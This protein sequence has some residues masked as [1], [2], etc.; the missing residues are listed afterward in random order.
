MAQPGT[1]LMT[2]RSLLALLCLFLGIAQANTQT[3]TTPGQTPSTAFPVCGT[4]TFSQSSVPQCGGRP[5]PNPK[6][7]G[8]GLT[9][10][11]PFWYKFTCFQSGTLG[12]L[13]TP[14]NLSDDYDWELYD[15]TSKDPDDVYKD[16][17]LVVASNWSGESGKTGSSASG[18]SLYV[19]GGY[20]KPLF[21][22]M[23]NL[24]AGHNYL[25]LVSHFTRTQSGYDLSFG[26]GTA[27]ITDS[28]IPKLKTVEA[29]C[30]GDRI[31]V[32]LNKKVKC[33]SLA[34]DGSD[35]FLSTP[36]YAITKATG[37]NCSAGFDMDSIELSLSKELDPGTYTLKVQ[38]GRDGNT[39]FDICDNALPTTEEMSFTVTPRFP[40]PMDS[41][42]AVTCA[43]QSLT[44]VFKKPM[45]CASIAA[46][47]SDFTVTG[48]Y[49]VTVASARGN[50]SGTPALSKEIILALSAPLQKAGNFTIT[51][52]RG[53]D[54]NTVVNECGEETP[55]GS[56]LSFTVKDTVNAGFTYIKKYGCTLDTINYFHPGTDGV[57][58]W[59]WNLDEGKTSTD[60]NP[61]ALYSVFNTKTVSL[62]VSNGFCSDTSSQTIV[63]DN[64]IKADF[65][66][67][68]D[69]CPNEAAQ[70]TGIPQGPVKQHAWSFG[71]GGTAD[72]QS[73]TYTFSTP[74]RTTVYT[75]RYTITDSLGCQSTAEKPVRVYV[76]CY[77]AVP[78]AFTPNRDGHNDYLRVL[79]AIK[80]EKLEF[81]VFNR[82]GQLL[83][84]TSDWK[85]GWDGT[86]KKIAQPTGVYVWFLSYTDRDSKERRESKGTATLIR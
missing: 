53:T 15:I 32:K 26:G 41:L 66:T 10:I 68:E 1:L 65:T 63:L 30:G 27:V 22:Q 29:N 77:L 4:S 75:I 70:F 57:N 28:T 82:W 38:A 48:P 9:D 6:C 33:A 72:I 19:C 17:S 76:S 2:I 71:D 43:P 13:I 78:S 81:K 46:D 79:N 85:Q 67:F 55:A 45:D 47:G 5:M 40:T 35:F 8:D 3:C 37:I 16:G 56:T 61:Q 51:L 60:Q 86:F 18:T 44:L 62:V 31:R 52:K 34:A 42:T 24:I 21:S 49:P 50:C 25:L 73:P 74:D 58:S 14:K 69:H 7:A 39:L 11:N 64:F 84:K 80:A 12:F 59:R 83:F 36:G 20:G 23:P 54:G